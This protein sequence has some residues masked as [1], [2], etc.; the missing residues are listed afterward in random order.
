MALGAT[1]E[2][3]DLALTPGHF[4]IGRPLR[5]LP[6]KPAS[7]AQLP[8]LRR[9]QLVQRLQQDLWH[10]WRGYYLQHLQTRRK[11]KGAGSTS[12]SIGDVVFLKDSILADGR[13]P[14]ARVVSVCPGTD[15]TVRVVEIKCDNSTYKRSIQSLVKLHL[16]DNSSTSATTTTPDAT[17]EA[18]TTS[19]SSLVLP[20]PSMFGTT[21]S[22]RQN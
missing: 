10:A 14:L 22:N 6:T 5:A 18:T 2:D 13:W 1:E 15:G 19:S 17:G 12:I 7:S 11:W 8:H 20:P 16:E 4:L 21:P 9:W 3:M